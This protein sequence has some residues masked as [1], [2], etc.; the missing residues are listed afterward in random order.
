MGADRIGPAS[1]RC[2][3][4][5]PD[6][7]KDVL[8]RLDPYIPVGVPVTHRFAVPI[9][10]YERLSII[11]KGMSFRDAKEAYPEIRRLL[12]NLGAEGD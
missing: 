4:S 12:E 9:P 2:H 7:P 10:H 3:M 5:E 6:D 1:A 11:L 8:I